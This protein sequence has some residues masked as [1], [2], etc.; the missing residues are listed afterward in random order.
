MKSRKAMPPLPS[1][2]ETIRVPPL[3]RGVESRRVGGEKPPAGVVN[4]PVGKG[5]AYDTPVDVAAEGHVEP[6]VGVDPIVLV[7]VGQQED[8]GVPQ[9]LPDLLRQLR[10]RHLVVGS[11]G[12]VNSGQDHGLPIPLQGQPLVG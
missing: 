9:G 8:I 1:P 6:A 7:A 4:Q 12:V 10:G 5:Q 3:S 2:R 11:V